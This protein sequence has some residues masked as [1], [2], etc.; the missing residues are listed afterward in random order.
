VRKLHA[1]GAALLVKEA[2]DTRE[3]VNVLVVVDAEVLRADASF[4]RYR[5]RL[6]HH[7]RRA[8]DGTGA[9]MHE[10]PVVGKPVCARVLAHGRDDDAVE[11]RE[12]ASDKWIK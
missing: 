5:R 1:R 7:E 12:A 11:K 9:E 10:V 6:R 4:G 8:A 3:H 2:N